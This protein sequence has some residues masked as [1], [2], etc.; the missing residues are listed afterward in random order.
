MYSYVMHKCTLYMCI[1]VC[2]ALT[3]LQDNFLTSLISA[4]A[5]SVSSVTSFTLKGSNKS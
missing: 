5:P 4:L 1:P 2:S 3:V